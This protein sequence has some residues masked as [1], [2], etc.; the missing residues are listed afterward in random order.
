[1]NRGFCPEAAGLQNI[2][3]GNLGVF[4]HTEADQK[5]FS[6]HVDPGVY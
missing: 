1:M 2:R 6:D 5:Y 3:L 4:A